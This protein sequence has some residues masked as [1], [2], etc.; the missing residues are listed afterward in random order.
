MLDGRAT[1]STRIHH[2]SNEILMRMGGQRWHDSM[3]V[4]TG[5]WE[6]LLAFARAHGKLCGRADDG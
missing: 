3:N 1:E 6:C 4:F 2:K 5:V